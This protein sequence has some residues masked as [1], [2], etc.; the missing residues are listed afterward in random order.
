MGRMDGKVAIVTGGAA[1]IG[2][3]TAVLLAAEGARVVVADRNRA[4]A[5]DVARRIGGAATAMVFD[6]ADAA[7][8]ETL[9]AETAA[10]F[11]RIDVLHN[12]AAMTAEAWSVD[13]TVLDTSIETWDLTFAVNLRSQFVS[14]KAV[15]PHMIR[16]GGGA[17]VNMASG[18]G[19]KGAAGLVA[20]GT[21]KAAVMAFTRYM[22]VQ[23]GRQ[24][25]RTNCVAPGVIMTEQLKQN[26]PQLERVTLRTL[27]F[28]RVGRPEDVAALV[29]YLASDDSGY[30]N[31][32]TF[33]CDGGSTAGAAPYTE[34]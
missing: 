10:L 20:Y 22:A 16:Q 5:E 23:Y 8:I 31:G 28:P 3:S 32:Q 27:P 26:A 34:Q 1:G 18:S 2:A 9:V 25:V 13:K 4:G 17:V 12:N 15:L 19:H 29:L 14:C 33:N 24:G 30:V 21:S 7:S 11:G 6:A